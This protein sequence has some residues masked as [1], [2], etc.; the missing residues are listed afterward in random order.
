VRSDINF[1]PNTAAAVA[2]GPQ[3]RPVEQPAACKRDDDYHQ[4]RTSTPQNTTGGDPNS[5]HEEVLDATQDRQAE[6]RSEL[7][8]AHEAAVNAGRREFMMQLATVFIDIYL[9]PR[10][11]RTEQKAA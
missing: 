11:S 2:P 6:Q 4:L 8:R 10:E 1:H 7:D 9:A 5:K 3:S